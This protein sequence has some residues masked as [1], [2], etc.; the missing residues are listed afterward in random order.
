M[1]YDIE[2]FDR[3]IE[4]LFEKSGYPGLTMTVRGP[5][6]IIYE[7]GFGKRSVEHDLPADPD[8]I[9]GIAS[10]S[11]SMTTL[12]LCILATEGKVSFDEPVCK[13]FPDFRVPGIPAECVTLK[14]LAMH[15]SGIPPIPP[16][17]WSIVMNSVERDTEYAR[18]L[19]ASAPNEMA[20]IDQIIAYIAAGDY[21]DP[22]YTTLGSPGEYMSYSNEGYAILSYVVDQ[23]AGVKLEDFLAERLFKPLG[24][25]RTVIDDTCAAAKAIAGGNI[26]SLF[27]R[28]AEGKL[29]WDDNWSIL[30]PYRGCAMVKSTSHDI[31]K[32]YQMLSN[33][34]Q[35]EGKQV[36]PAAAVE[37]LIGQAF[38]LQRWPFYCYGLKK[39]LFH[40]RTICEHSGGL[41]GVSTSGGLIDGGYSVAV[42]CN[43]GE[44]DTDWFQW[45]GYNLILGLPFDTDHH[46]AL[47]NGTAFSEPQALVGDYLDME[48][49]PAHNIVTCEDGVLKADYCGTKVD[50]RHCGEAKF[51]CYSE[52]E[53]EK[54]ITTM[55]F[56]VR[57]GQAWACRCGTRIFERV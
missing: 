25:T 19:R 10:M 13:F 3:Y 57:Q 35:W 54:R 46:W 1:T 27:E 2:S 36:I 23:V 52:K 53:P 41:H 24:M 30:P 22:H 9:F 32:Y 15:T 56:Y 38:P 42:L 8:T 33:G 6:G 26:T 21:G 48:G 43:E 16:L 55:E 37:M 50:M 14:H 40:G 11:K 39:R 45:A 47:P 5:E 28:D 34:G 20:T 18:K 31:S 4:N 7:R 44:V 49:N 12:A 51:V 29:I 17:E